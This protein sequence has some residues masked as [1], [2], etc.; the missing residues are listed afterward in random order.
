MHRS[1]F[2]SETLS[3]KFIGDLQSDKA[4]ID[5]HSSEKSKGNEEDDNS[6]KK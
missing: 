3:S 4:D 1:Q 5:F 2:H 6:S